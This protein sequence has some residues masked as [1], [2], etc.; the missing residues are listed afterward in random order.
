MLSVFYFQDSWRQIIP[1]IFMYVNIFI[2]YLLHKA[3]PNKQRMSEVILSV[4]LK[5]D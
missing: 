1:G 4:S 5:E 2:K 3:S